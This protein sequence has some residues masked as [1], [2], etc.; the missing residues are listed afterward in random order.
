MDRGLEERE[1]GKGGNFPNKFR[2]ILEAENL[3]REI[4]MDTNPT[5]FEV[6]LLS[7]CPQSS[8]SRSRQA[9]TQVLT[10]LQ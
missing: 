2:M 8:Y 6:H 5:I 3:C 1:G 10:S 9:L 7:S 4:K